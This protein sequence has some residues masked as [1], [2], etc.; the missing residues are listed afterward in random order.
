MKY[1]I[2][3]DTGGTFTDC[4]GRD[5][6]GN[7]SRRK[8]LSNGSLRGVVESWIDQK[9]LMIRENWDLQRD[10]LRGYQFQLLR[11]KHDIT[12][13][14]CFDL[15]QHIL[16]LTKELPKSLCKQNMSFEIR[17]TEVAPVLGARLIT[18]TPLDLDLPRLHM[19]LG[20]TWGTNALL[21]RKGADI[22]LFVTRGFRDILEIGNQQRPDIFALE[23]V[24]REMLYRQVIEVEERIDVTGNVIIPLNVKDFE[25]KLLKARRKGFTS[26]AICLLNS[27]MN[28]VHEI[29]LAGLLRRRGVSDI[30]VSTDLSPLIK[31]VNRTETAVVNA[32]LNPVIR[33]YLDNVKDSI[34]NG[35]VHVMTSSGGLI[36]EEHFS[37]KDSLL[38][39]PAG[40][41]VGAV[42]IGKRNGMDHII[43]FDM[44]GTST[45][46]SR[47]DGQYDYRYDLEVG[48]AHIFSPAL[49]IETVA[50]GGG[51]LCYYDGFKLSV[52]P[53]SAGANPGPA[54]YG[55]GGPVTITDV[56]LLLGRLD[57]A[58]FGIPVFMKEASRKLD[59]LIGEILKSS[60]KRYIPEEILTGFHDIANEVM[61][62]AIRKISIARGYDPAGYVLVAFGGAGGM[63][64]CKIASLLGMQTVVVPADAGLL[65]AYGLANAVIERF[66]EKLVLRPYEEI[67]SDLGIWIN[68]LGRQ[69]MAEVKKE[70]GN[71]HVIVRFRTV[72]LRFMG[73]DESLPVP[74]QE[75]EDLISL[76]RE[77]Y[78][79]IYGHWTENR[80]I[81]VE[82][83]RVAAAEQET[84]DERVGLPDKT[85]HPEPAKSI[86]SYCDGT[87][88][89]IPVFNREDLE[90][91]AK[92][93]GQAL[94]IDPYSTTVIEKGWEVV[95]NR[96]GAAI[97]KDKSQGKT[98]HRE[99]AAIKETRLEL[100]TNRFRFIAENMGAML[101]RTSISV[102]IKERL[103]FSCALVGPDGYLVANAPHIPVHLGS[104]GVCVRSLM[105]KIKMD[106]GDTI[107]TNHPA[108]G[109]SHLPDVTLVTPVF[110]AGGELLG[111][112]VNRAHH[113]ELG[114]SRPASM[115]P[116]ATSLEEE[117][118]IIEPFRL[119]S[120]G[121]VNWK[122]MR[123]ILE[124]GPW[125]SRAVEENIADL[126]AALA[127]N[128]AGA[129]G[130]REL[131][132][133]HG[134]GQVIDYMVYLRDY[135]ASRMR[136]VLGRIPDGRYE[137]QEE[138]D[139][140]SILKAVIEISQDSCSIDFTGSSGV[141]PGNMNATYAIVNSVVIYVLRLL[142]KEP[143]PLNE[144]ILEPVRIILPE[145]LL[146]P[147]FSRSRQECP[148]IVGGNVEVSQRL[149]DTLLKAF[150]VV[151]CSQGTMNNLMMGNE[152]YSYYETIC[153]G[154]GAGPG[155]N[156]ASGVHH[157]MTNTRITDPEILEHRY[158]LRL[159]KFF[160]RKGSG[161]R[162]AYSGGDGVVR[163]LE[164]TSA[165]T[166][167]IL[168]Q[169]R[170]IRPYGMQGGKRGKRGRQQVI[171]A[172]GAT[173]K[174]KG[175]DG[176]TAYPGDRLVVKTP[177]GG[178]WGK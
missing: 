141:H 7:W 45:D 58:A 165:A 139:D 51:S 106:P 161:G 146:N 47:Y 31:Y 33:N 89:N 108:Y 135:A 87:W 148:A 44:G 175:I 173:E 118:V 17:S 145:S 48:G 83:I 110:T 81:E 117:G 88:R 154:C 25:K 20:S 36:R 84:G 37:A 13:I 134:T 56:N 143:L 163:I 137:A 168:S 3:V 78:T 35:R 12:F 130:L 27:F 14:Q 160:I 73:Q 80:E 53:E 147:D 122:G 155:F 57:P 115:P 16:R 66:A 79:R 93:S 28:P 121:Q 10:I 102:N 126:N 91:G 21:E 124:S 142:L 24:K 15:E 119:A 138:L 18:N 158:P 105:G 178:G 150:G 30:S 32:Y 120:S 116:D 127:A 103:D 92:V 101:Q 26:A 54:C 76:F 167:S 34:S 109:G 60:G 77:Q 157:H 67:K 72:F 75:G 55:A 112:V 140:N 123:E 42:T 1:E 172:D 94:L 52:G 176:I 169:H 49:S 2:Y 50:A 38:S 128:L 95:I 11:H 74:W 9:T 4:L 85:Y 114:G 170:I 86:S 129:G 177:G 39:G 46:V 136:M 166:V 59:E 8:V 98:G 22:V 68:E 153:G 19:K 5:P 159:M 132:E 113:A 162:G 171:R 104:L 65:S 131:A 125:P 70:G 69:A 64:A 164:F 100:F 111:Y 29:E 62:G 71:R 99:K 156:G 43:S 23:V 144:G 6:E 61:A 174:L 90:T 133:K 151:A 152:S 82:S 96:Y 149:T 40:G 97:I 107:V 41:V 63:H